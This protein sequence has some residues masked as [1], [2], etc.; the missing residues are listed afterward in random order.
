MSEDVKKLIAETSQATKD[1]VRVYGDMTVALAD[2]KEKLRICNIDQLNAETRITELEAERAKVIEVCG[3]I[4]SGDTATS[5]ARSI[6]SI[7]NDKK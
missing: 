3:F 7:L 6:L 5:L 4:D 1:F 2:L